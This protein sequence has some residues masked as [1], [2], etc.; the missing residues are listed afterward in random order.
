MS[1]ASSV[2]HDIQ[3]YKSL[4]DTPW[5]GHGAFRCLPH[6]GHPQRLNSLDEAQVK[7]R[8][9]LGPPAA[10]RAGQDHRATW[11]CLAPKA[12][13]ARST[14]EMLGAQLAT[15]QK[16]LVANWALEMASVDAHGCGRE[17]R[18]QRVS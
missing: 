1:R 7:D 9:H 4:A 11:P 8:R 17:C 2:A 12:A 16:Q 5:S 18:Q 13:T 10:R 15:Y 14:S 6:A 3:E